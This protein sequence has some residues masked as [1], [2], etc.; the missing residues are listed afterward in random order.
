MCALVCIIDDG[1]FYIILTESFV[2][3]E[4]EYNFQKL[5]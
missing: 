3:L 5:D 4:S 1:K 2:G